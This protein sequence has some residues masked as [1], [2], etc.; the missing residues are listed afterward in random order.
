VSGIAD[1]KLKPQLAAFPLLRPSSSFTDEVERI[2]VS[3]DN[4]NLE[5]LQF[6]GLHMEG[7]CEEGEK[8]VAD[9]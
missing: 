4:N 2:F 6:E 8:V 5:G 3:C 7:N 1:V 9:S